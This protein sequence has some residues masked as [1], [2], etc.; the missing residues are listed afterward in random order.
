[1]YGLTVY[2][3]TN[4]PLQVEKKVLFVRCVNEIRKSWTQNAFVSTTLNIRLRKS[5]N[6]Q[7]NRQ[8]FYI[9]RI[10]IN[11][12]KFRLRKLI[13]CKSLQLLRAVG[14]KYGDGESWTRVQGSCYTFFYVCSS[15]LIFRMNAG[16]ERSTI[17]AS[18]IEFF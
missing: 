2:L 18:L 9:N 13:L 10:Y 7:R 17:H 3:F 4:S 11:E 15:R 16:R 1:M 8:L 5:P 12:L 6:C 14:F